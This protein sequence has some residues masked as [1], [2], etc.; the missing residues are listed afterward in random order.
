MLEWAD[1][2]VVEV[3]H[4]PTRVGMSA[5]ARPA[6]PR[7]WPAW[8]AWALWLLA[9]LGL[10]TVPW[11]DRLLRHARRPELTQLDASTIPYLLALTVAVAV[12]FGVTVSGL[13]V[14]AA[15]LVV[16]FR[17]ARGVERQQLRWLA[18]A[19]ALVGVGAAVVGV[20]MAMGATAVP[21]FAAGVCLVL[22]PL[23]TGAA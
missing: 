7:W 20:G 1:R 21:L 14:G 12:A 15:S 4:A 8:L 16:R 19:A 10:A 6:R 13:A 3:A 22:L 17:R 2:A 5:Q 18:L 9:L 11:F 23:A